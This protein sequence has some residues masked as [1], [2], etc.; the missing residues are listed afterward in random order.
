ML[1]ITYCCIFLSKLISFHFLFFEGDITDETDVM[2]SV[3]P[4]GIRSIT[5]G[6]SAMG[7]LSMGRSSMM[8]K[9]ALNA[10]KP[11]TKI[12][13]EKKL[14]KR[15]ITYA[16]NFNGVQPHS[17][18]NKMSA[19]DLP[20]SDE[21]ARSEKWLQRSTIHKNVLGVP[22]YD[23]KRGMFRNSSDIPSYSSI[24]TEDKDKDNDDDDYEDL[25]MGRNLGLQLPNT[26]H[27]IES[28]NFKF[29]SGDTK[30]SDENE[31]KKGSGKSLPEFDSYQSGASGYRI[32][33][34][35]SHLHLHDDDV[36]LDTADASHGK[37]GDEEKR[38]MLTNGS[39]GRD[40]RDGRDGREI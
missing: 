10:S 31:S 29:Y 37:K 5:G 8:Q 3:F 20:N 7:L 40:N 11:F 16:N 9:N 33:K 35:S 27:R 39:H 30:S 36:T 18:R 22:R 26:F 19:K 4:M 24:N 23:E 15:S 34:T 14:V 1:T 6:K 17:V 25:E 21:V 38:I 28:D 32:T 12:E 13:D 2:P